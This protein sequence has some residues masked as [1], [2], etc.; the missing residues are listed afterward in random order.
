MRSRLIGGIFIF[1]V[2]FGQAQAENTLVPGPDPTTPLFRFDADTNVSTS[3]PNVTAW[4]NDTA[5]STGGA[6]NNFTTGFAGATLTPVVGHPSFSQAVNFAGASGD[7]ISFGPAVGPD[8]SFE[9]WFRPA[10][11]G[12]QVLFDS[13]GTGSGLGIGMNADGS[14]SLN[15]LTPQNNI[16]SNRQLT[17]ADI[18]DFTQLVA[19]VDSTDG[20][21]RL[22]LDGEYDN[23][24]AGVGTWSL[25]GDGAGIGGF[26]ASNGANIPGGDFVG[27][28][29]MF[30]VF[31]EP[32]EAD[33]VLALYLQLNP[34]PELAPEP[35]TL[36]LFASVV[37]GMGAVTYFRRSRR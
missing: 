23:T 31:A 17:A 5:N 30:R 35:G 29:A 33:Q 32:L 27:E 2:L 24:V 20:E 36:M 12:Q 10:A 13:G 19:V 37:C 3:G 4:G 6:G 7:G 25:G 34:T 16:T 18:Q 26:N 21:L 11:I 15:T 1:A 22:Y 8:A 28:I 9:I 14:L